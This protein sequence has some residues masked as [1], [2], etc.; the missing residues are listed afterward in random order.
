MGKRYYQPPFYDISDEVLANAANNPNCKNQQECLETLAHRKATS[1][2]REEQEAVRVVQEKLRR[3]L[4]RAEL[5][6]NPFD[7]RHEISVRRRAHCE[8]SW[9]ANRNALVDYFVALP[10]MLALLYA[11]VK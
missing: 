1:A 7:P 9:R 2:K 11:M 10:F 8:S 4:F 3:D 6:D 5:Q